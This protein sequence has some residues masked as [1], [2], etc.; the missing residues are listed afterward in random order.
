MGAPFYYG[1]LTDVT[2]VPSSE[3]QGDDQSGC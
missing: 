2:S 3:I 1:A